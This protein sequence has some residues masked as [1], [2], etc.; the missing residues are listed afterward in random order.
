MPAIDGNSSEKNAPLRLL[1]LIGLE[2][3][4]DDSHRQENTCMQATTNQQALNSNIR[5]SS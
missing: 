1:L 5:I 3:L 2:V 4:V